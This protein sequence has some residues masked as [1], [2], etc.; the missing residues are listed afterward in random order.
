MH[1][2]HPIGICKGYPALNR[3]AVVALCDLRSQRLVCGS[4]IEQER[5]SWREIWN[6][7]NNKFHC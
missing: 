7:S 5:G 2:H 4:G 6:S 3:K 1:A